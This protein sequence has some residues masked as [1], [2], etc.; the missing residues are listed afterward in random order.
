MLVGVDK[1]INDDKLLR[2]FGISKNLWPALRY[3]WDQKQ[4]DMQ[5]RFD[6]VYDGT[7]P[8]KMLEYNADTPSLIIESGDL[9]LDWFRD[10]YG[11]RFD[12]FQSNYIKEFLKRSMTKM[13]TEC[14][15]AAFVFMYEDD[16]NVS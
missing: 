2:L 4:L 10:T 6:L 1:V 13:S 12:V 15:S 5:G 3:S 16:E 8:P 11:E 9:Q 7:N 14:D